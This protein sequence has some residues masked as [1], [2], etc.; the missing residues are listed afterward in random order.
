MKMILMTTLLAAV[1]GAGTEP[2][3]GTWKLN[4]A[5]SKLRTATKSSVA[6]ITQAGNERTIETHA[7]TADGKET[8]VKST[9][10]FDG[11]KHPYTGTPANYDSYVAKGS[12]YTS[13]VEYKRAGKVV[14]TYRATYSK[15]GKT[16]TGVAKG[17]DD[18]GKAYN[19]LFVY[20]RQ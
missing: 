7:V 17:V 8:H 18:K 6:T 5:K 14:R 10:I 13:V 4:V 20:D 3:V 15:D 16:R 12:G 11:K 2:A 19:D 9:H 1:L